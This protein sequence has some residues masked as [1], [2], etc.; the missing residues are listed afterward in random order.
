MSTGGVSSS[1]AICRT[2]SITAASAETLRTRGIDSVA[3]LPNLVPGLTLQE[4]NFASTSF[5]LRGVGFFNSDLSTPPA[6]TSA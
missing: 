3:D 6:V 1:A 4:S 5:T 2:W